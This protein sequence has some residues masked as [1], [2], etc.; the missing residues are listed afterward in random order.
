[1]LEKEYKQLLSAEEYEALHAR[2]KWDS[3]AEQINNY[4]TDDDGVFFK[5]KIMFRVREKNGKRVIQVKRKK[6]ENSP[7]QI[8]VENEFETDSVPETIENPERYTGIK[9]GAIHRIGSAVT[10]RSS[11]MWDDKTEICLDKTT[12][13]GVTDYEIEIEYTADDIP[14]AL[15][16]ELKK[17]NVSFT[18]KAIGKFSRF[19]N[20]YEKL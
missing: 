19:L 12:Y 9:S 15:K 17:L 11:E 6:S 2:F 8:C 3:E 1:M 5:N 14:D 20:E 4:Y 13:F 18:D 7:L 10:L 16:D